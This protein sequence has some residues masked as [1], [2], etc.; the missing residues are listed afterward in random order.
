MRNITVSENIEY[1]CQPEI[2]LY[3]KSRLYPLEVKSFGEVIKDYRK[4][5][6][7]LTF[8]PFQYN[9]EVKELNSRSIVSLDSE[10]Y[11]FVI[12]KISKY[13]R[14]VGACKNCSAWQDNYISTKDKIKASIL[15]K[16][17]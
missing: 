9:N 13:I 11:E 8:K 7:I 10:E 3:G 14:S 2:V 4:A 6:C 15:N 17:K 5:G 1:P 16:L 12:G